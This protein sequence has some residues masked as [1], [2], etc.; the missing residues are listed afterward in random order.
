MCRVYAE[1]ISFVGKECNRVSRARN[2][3]MKKWYSTDDGVKTVLV[4]W[5]L[6]LLADIQ[7][8]IVIQA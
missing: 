5:Y 8:E 3:G 4:T 2:C 6:V 1:Q 7:I